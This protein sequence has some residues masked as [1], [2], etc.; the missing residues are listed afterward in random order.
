VIFGATGLAGSGLPRYGHCHATA[1]VA[2]ALAPAA[3]ACG[4]WL[5]FEAY[6]EPGGI[7]F[8]LVLGVTLYALWDFFLSGNYR[9]APE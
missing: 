8:W 7:W 4:L 3:V 5:A 2:E 6:Y 9:D 1:S